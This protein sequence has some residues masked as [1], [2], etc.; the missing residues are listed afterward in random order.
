MVVSAISDDISHVH[1]RVTAAIGIAAVF[2]T[3]IPLSA[4]RGL[5]DWVQWV[6]IV[7]VA[8]LFASGAAYFQYTQQLNKLRLKIVSEAVPHIDNVDAVGDWQEHFDKSRRWIF[9]RKTNG[10]TWNDRSIWLFWAGQLF[11]FVGLVLVAVVLVWLIPV[12]TTTP[13]APLRVHLQP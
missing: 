8:I 2:V 1:V 5:P 12:H 4:L 13:S 10:Y 11:L 3:Q 9:M 6:T 7:A